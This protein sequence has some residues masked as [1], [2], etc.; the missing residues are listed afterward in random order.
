GDTRKTF[1]QQLHAL[2]DQLTRDHGQP[3]EVSTRPSEAGDE[4]RLN[5]IGK[6]HKD[7]RNCL[8]RVSRNLR[9]RS[10]ESDDAADPEA[11]QLGGDS[12]KVCV[13]LRESILDNDILSFDVAEVFQSLP[14]R[15]GPRRCAAGEETYPRNPSRMLRPSAERR[16][17]EGSQA[18]H[19]GATVHPADLRLAGW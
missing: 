16:S 3:R 5:R 2:A 7:N 17:E 11:D 14:E 19:E 10:P 9:C 1:L 8:D 15:V 4:S 18:S 12:A 6:R 13:A